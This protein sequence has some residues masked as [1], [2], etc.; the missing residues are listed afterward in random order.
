ANEIVFSPLASGARRSAGTNWAAPGMQYV[1][2][3]RPAA[4]LPPSCL[5]AV[6]V[7][8]IAACDGAVRDG[9]RSITGTD[10]V[11]LLFR[12]VTRTYVFHGSF[13]IGL[14]SVD[15][16]WKPF[17]G[18]AQPT[19]SGCRRVFTPLAVSPESSESS[20]PPNHDAFTSLTQR[21]F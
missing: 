1:T 13:G 20:G 5:K 18:S 10:S 3:I 19:I 15:G 9:P 7:R 4:G 16:R 8:S 17:I 14:P 12:F 11:L 2:D 6:S 21:S